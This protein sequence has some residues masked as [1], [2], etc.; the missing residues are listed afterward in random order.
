[1]KTEIDEIVIQEVDVWDICNRCQVEGFDFAINTYTGCTFDCK[2]CYACFMSR[3]SKH[4]EE[5]GTFLDVKNWKSVSER[6]VSGKRIIIGT[7]TDPYNPLEEKFRRTRKVLE[8]LSEIDCAVTIQTK[9]KLVL[10]DI[11]ILK[12]M[13]DVKVAISLCTLDEKIASDL[14]YELSVKE[15]IETMKALHENG[16][17]V[18]LF[19]SPIL[20]GLSEIEAIIN[21]CGKYASEIWFDALELRNEFRSRILKYIKESHP[22]LVNLYNKIYRENDQ[23]YWKKVKEEIK[24]L[25]KDKVIKDRIKIF[26]K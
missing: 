13:S 21:K 8:E 2:F 20:P 14:E 9:S 22:N 23:T 15:R 19:I 26:E 12:K 3:F 5:W 10:D 6:K 11:E 17:G 25:C 18:V 24:I 16:V 4:K 7:V 1:M